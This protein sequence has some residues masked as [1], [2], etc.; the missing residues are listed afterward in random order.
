[1]VENEAARAEQ[2]MLTDGPAADKASDGYTAARM[3]LASLRTKLRD[4]S[5]ITKKLTLIEK[6]RE[7]KVTEAKLDRKRGTKAVASEENT[8]REAQMLAKQ[9]R[10]QERLSREERSSSEKAEAQGLALQHPAAALLKDSQR[11][12]DQSNLVL[13]QS[14][15]AQAK[16][17]AAL[18]LKLAQSLAARASKGMAEARNDF[19]LAIADRKKAVN[20]DT[21]SAHDVVKDAQDSLKTNEEQP[22]LLHVLHGQLTGGA[23]LNAVVNTDTQGLMNA[24]E[25]LGVERDQLIN[26]KRSVANV[27]AQ[28]AV[29]ADEAKALRAEVRAAETEVLKAAHEH[30]TA[31]KSYKEATAKALSSQTSLNSLRQADEKKQRAQLEA[32][33]AK[34]KE[35]SQRCLPH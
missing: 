29:L 32:A 10:H 3:N 18:D 1:M 26:E 14:H 9:A 34:Q 7:A 30:V 31:L 25:T 8:L 23:A 28:L 2:T 4:N 33:K 21:A 22:A 16:A 11:L 13:D 6:Q 12:N 24:E 19:A 20:D 5:D 17:L 27:D 35:S 15:S